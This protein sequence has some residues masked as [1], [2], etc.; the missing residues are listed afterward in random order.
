MI[1]LSALTLEK[2]R[3]I[4]T[5]QMGWVAMMCQVYLSFTFNATVSN[6]NTFVISLDAITLLNQAH[7]R[8]VG[9][10]MPGFLKLFRPRTL[11]Y[12]CVSAPEGI[13]NKSRERHA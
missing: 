2:L 13:N 3:V 11:V 8:A 10:R 7:V 9:P 4:L 12:V 1:Y 6:A 5:V